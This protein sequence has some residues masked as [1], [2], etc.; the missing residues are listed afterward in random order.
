M[1]QKQSQRKTKDD[2]P[3]K[4]KD[5]PQKIMDKSEQIVKKHIMKSKKS[6]V[7]KS[8]KNT[9][10]TRNETNDY[11]N[12]SD[13]DEDLYILNNLPAIKNDR[14]TDRQNKSNNN[15]LHHNLTKETQDKG[16]DSNGSKLLFFSSMTTEDLSS[17]F[18]VDTPPQTDDDDDDEEED[19]P[20]MIEPANPSEVLEFRYKCI[21]KIF[22]KRLKAAQK[23]NV[24]SHSKDIFE[25]TLTEGDSRTKNK[26]VNNN[27]IDNYIECIDI[28][29]EQQQQQEQLEFIPSSLLSVE[30]SPV[31]SNSQC[32]KNKVISDTDVNYN[33]LST[34]KD[35]GQLVYDTSPVISRNTSLHCASTPKTVSKS[36]LK[37]FAHEFTSEVIS[38]IPRNNTDGLP[39]GNKC[40]READKLPDQQLN[41]RNRFK[42]KLSIFAKPEEPE[43]RPTAK[44]SP[45]QKDKLSASNLHVKGREKESQNALHDGYNDDE[46]PHECNKS[47]IHKSTHTVKF[48]TVVD[49]EPPP[50]RN[51][52]SFHFENL[53][54]SQ[55]SDGERMEE[56]VSNKRES[57]TNT[58]DSIKNSLQSSWNPKKHIQTKGKVNAAGTSQHNVLKVTEIDSKDTEKSTDNN[59]SPD[60]MEDCSLF[61]NLT[62]FEAEPTHIQD[63]SS[64]GVSVT[65]VIRYMNEG[66][67]TQLTPTT[68]ATTKPSQI[69]SQNMHKNKSYAAD[70]MA[71]KCSVNLS[72]NSHHN[73]TLKLN[74]K[75]TG[76]CNGSRLSLSKMSKL[77]TKSNPRIEHKTTPL[78]NLKEKHVSLSNH[79]KEEVE[80]LSESLL[81]D[82][83]FKLLE[84]PDENDVKSGKSDKTS[85]LS[86][87]FFDKDEDLFNRTQEGRKSQS[88]TRLPLSNKQVN[89]EKSQK[90]SPKSRLISPKSQLISPKSHLTSP[91]Q[92]L[93]QFL[94]TRKHKGYNVVESDC[95]DSII[96]T[97]SENNISKIS[98]TS[99]SNRTNAVNMNATTS[100][101]YE[102]ND[103]DDFED[104]DFVQTF[105]PPRP[106]H[107]KQNNEMKKKKKVCICILTKKCMLFG[108]LYIF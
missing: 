29:D 85:S 77:S 54:L 27:T 106:K 92:D 34:P 63:S 39:R 97:D 25:R 51:N 96:N 43:L 93:T 17:S 23:S 76:N 41:N 37:K 89:K 101:K 42:A 80:E 11:I 7:K 73:S 60:M 46:I 31:M 10:M 45:I 1:S 103:D 5:Y 90:T 102:F 67:S 71:G 3:P 33:I 59:S 74:T 64:F 6:G 99:G 94:V 47:V 72:K 56:N 61:E 83:N 24:S 81:A 19:D 98:T 84:I 22:K 20:M 26:S 91:T 104:E 52:S 108:D 105:A 68:N 88:F 35:D 4:N 62:E 30:G 75:S 58:S 14:Q 44:I 8:T 100:P 13:D 65:Q 49:I 28:D 18:S 40:H 36:L 12:I 38:P 79:E 15:S 9:I 70:E 86:D 95:E 55:N 32:T 2:N 69:H 82:I 87:T 16:Q 50:S 21:N 66:H 78:H 57:Y 107:H 48:N 53:N